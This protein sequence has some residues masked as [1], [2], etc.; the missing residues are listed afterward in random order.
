[1][2]AATDRSEIFEQNFD[3]NI[4]GV[5]ASPGEKVPLKGAR[6]EALIS[7]NCEILG[8]KLTIVQRQ[9]AVFYHLGR[10]VRGQNTPT[11]FAKVFRSFEQLLYVSKMQRPSHT[12][13]VH[14]SSFK[15]FFL[16]SRLQKE[17]IPSCVRTRDASGPRP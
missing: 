15:I 17:N 6:L 5:P 8:K 9:N 2:H 4:R 12:V 16:K 3:C 13:G 11:R 1:M 14:F 7:H 10:G